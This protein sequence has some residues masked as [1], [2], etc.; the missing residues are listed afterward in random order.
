MAQVSLFGGQVEVRV[1][2]NWEVRACGREV[3]FAPENGHSANGRFAPGAAVSEKTVFD[4][5]GL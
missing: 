3:G 2:S 5:I 4:P 1:G